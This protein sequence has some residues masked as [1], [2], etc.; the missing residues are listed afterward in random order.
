MGDETVLAMDSS[1]S[2]Y[3][4]PVNYAIIKWY[5]LCIFYHKFSAFSCGLH[6]FWIE[7]RV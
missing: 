6:F 3:L 2:D 4:V 1:D 7:F 5:T